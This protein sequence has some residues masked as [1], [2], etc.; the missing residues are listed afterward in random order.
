MKAFVLTDIGRYEE[1]AKLIDGTAD[2]F[3]GIP[4]LRAINFV[5]LG[6]PDDARKEI[7]KVLTVQ[8]WYTAARR[9]D[10]TFNIKLAIIDRQVADLVKAGLPEK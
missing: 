8:P 4:L 2:I 7:D 9:R 1:S 10:M 5:H 6:R 3:I